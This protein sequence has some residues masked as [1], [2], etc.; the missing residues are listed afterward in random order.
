MANQKVKKVAKTPLW[1]L[2]LRFMISFGG[3]LTIVF[4]AAEL[5]KSGN[6]N[7]I[8][9]SFKDGSWYPFVATRVAIIVGYGFVMA[10]LTKSKAKNM[11]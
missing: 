9:E 2:A 7:A 3:I 1:K 8:S 10:F 5:F 6:L 11:I 4:V